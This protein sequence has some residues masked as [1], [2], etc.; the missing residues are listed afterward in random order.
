MKYL[1]AD[2]IRLGNLKTVASKA[3]A[4]P[5]GGSDAYLLLTGGDTNHVFFMSG[6]SKGRGFPAE[7]MRTETAMIIEGIEIEVDVESS[8]RPAY[9]EQPIGSVR[10]AGSSLGLGFVSPGHGTFDE[11]QHVGFDAASVT[12]SSPDRAAIDFTR[13][14]V[15]KSVGTERL[16]LAE[17]EADEKTR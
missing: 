16:V 7:D 12:V 14:R 2:A 8:Y 5:L 9:I 17:Y 10:V 4:K 1:P 11:L 3:L 15:I 6:D 13:W